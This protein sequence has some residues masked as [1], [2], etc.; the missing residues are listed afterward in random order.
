MSTWTGGVGVMQDTGITVPDMAIRAAIRL[1]VAASGG[2]LDPEA[3]FA[4]LTLACGARFHGALAPVVNEQTGR[5]Q[6]R[7]K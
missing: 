6:A 3:P 5:T 4:N 7:A 1:L 2:Y